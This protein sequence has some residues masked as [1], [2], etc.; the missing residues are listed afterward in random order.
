MKEIAFKIVRSAFAGKVD[1]GGRP[2][3]EHLERVAENT[4]EF[5][6][7]FE[8]ARKYYDTIY[9]VALLHD[10][11]EDCG[12]MWTME[13]LKALIGDVNVLTALD[14][15]TKRK[16]T[17]YDDYIFQISKDRI[18]RVVKLADLMDN[19]NIARLNKELTDE[20]LVRLKKYHKAYLFLMKANK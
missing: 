13:H 19:M 17:P 7:S 3:I 2:Y 4:A 18:A 1:K 11:I 15:L 9:V 12:D 8:G 5:I 20:D 14:R 6:K 16:E 10:L